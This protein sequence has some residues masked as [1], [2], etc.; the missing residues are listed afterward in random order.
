MKKPKQLPPEV[1]QYVP[2]IMEDISEHLT[3]DFSKEDWLSLYE[4][5]MDGDL[6]S[7]EMFC[8]LFRTKVKPYLNPDLFNSEQ[9]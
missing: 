1:R 2:Q 8:A 9:N 7:L 3:P 5:A 4:R 6:T